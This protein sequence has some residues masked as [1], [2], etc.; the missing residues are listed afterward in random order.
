MSKYNKIYFIPGL[1]TDKTIYK[2]VINELNAPC[3]VIEFKPLEVDES[4]NDYAKKMAQEIDES[5]PFAIVGT[6]FG[7]ILAMEI[8]KIKHPEKLI[9]ISSAKNREELNPIMRIK[10]GSFFVSL[11]PDKIMK[12]IFNKGF[13][14]SSFVRKSYK[15]IY[16]EETKAMIAKSTGGFDK[17]VM[18]QIASWKSDYLH[19]DILHIHGDKDVVFPIKHIRKCH[20]I[21][22][23]SHAMIIN[24]YEEIGNVITDFLQLEKKV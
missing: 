8:A 11:I 5:K 19:Q 20:V 1:A 10:G 17:W 14:I 21:S 12:Q 15:S 13:H 23:G 4:L 24:K 6:S 9:L 16:N 2:G 18:L 22:G 7:G 3:E